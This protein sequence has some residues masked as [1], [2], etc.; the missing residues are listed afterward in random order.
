MGGD[1]A[2][3]AIL[4]YGAAGGRPC[5]ATGT[6][7]EASL[8]PRDATGTELEA[9]RPPTP[10]SLFFCSALPASSAS[11]SASLSFSGKSYIGTGLRPNGDEAMGLSG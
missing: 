10:T 11:I 4:E 2:F 7:L 8:E 5:D 1:V 3:G 9:A 6:E